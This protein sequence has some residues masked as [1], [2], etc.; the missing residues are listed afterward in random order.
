MV[1]FQKSV[2]LK[3][4]ENKLLENIALMSNALTCKN[5]SL[6][7]KKIAKKSPHIFEDKNVFFSV[8][9]MLE[10]YRFKHENRKYILSFFDKLFFSDDI[11]IKLDTNPL[12]VRS[13]I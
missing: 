8:I 2:T 1:A 9:L 11:F 6:E 7:I 5:S 13:I 10:F 12:L 3:E 4:E